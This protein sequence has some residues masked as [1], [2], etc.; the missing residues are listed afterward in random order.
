MWFWWQLR[1]V[2]ASKCQR[3]LK[4]IWW[5]AGWLEF[6]WNMSHI[7]DVLSQ[8][9]NLQEGTRAWHNKCHTRRWFEKNK[10]SATQTKPEALS[11]RLLKMALN[12]RAV[13]NR[14]LKSKN[15]TILA[16]IKFHRFLYISSNIII[17]EEACIILWRLAERTRWKLNLM[18]ISKYDWDLFH[19][20]HHL[21]PGCGYRELCSCVD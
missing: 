2:L 4:I 18:F 6:L 21:A 14:Q 11:T 20:A 15:Q 13:A 10:C 9:S 7:Q 1:L 8:Q 19:G 3:F 16:S 12:R 5:N 17:K